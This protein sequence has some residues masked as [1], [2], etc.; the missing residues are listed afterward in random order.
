V[1]RTVQDDSERAVRYTIS[2]GPVVTINVVEL[3]QPDRIYQGRLVDLSQCGAKFSV[4][5]E[6]ATNKSI[7]LKISVAE[8]GMEFYVAG[9]LCWAKPGPD[10]NWFAGCSLEPGLPKNFFDQLARD[11]RINRRVHDRFDGFTNLGACF[12]V[13]G[14]LTPV[15]LK[16][17]SAGGFCVLSQVPAPIGHRFNLCIA[18]PEEAVM[19]SQTQWQLAVR[20][21]YLIGCL[22]LDSNDFE[23]LEALL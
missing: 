2:N 15:T 6:I 7:R 3:Y 18:E 16:N 13:D 11:G 4:P 14:E 9:S 12:D 1:I 20:D 8:L 10:G 19:P 22:L 5:E 23:R 17:Y 21:G